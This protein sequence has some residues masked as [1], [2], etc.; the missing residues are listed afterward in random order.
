MDIKPYPKNAKK[1]PNK[2]LKQIAD[3]VKRFGWQQPVVVDKDGVI[4]VGHGRWAAYEKHGLEKPPIQVADKLTKKEANAYRLA[5]NKLNERRPP[6]SKASTV[7][8][9]RYN[10][11]CFTRPVSSR[12]LSRLWLYSHSSR[13]NRKNMLRNGT[14]P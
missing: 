5:D 8:G 1:H 11:Y 7:S 13:K 9:R 2:Q 6:N 12:P 3:S 14:R 4:I 10:L